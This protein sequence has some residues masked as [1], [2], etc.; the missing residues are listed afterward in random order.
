MLEG[1]KI[2]VGVTGS[3]AAY[4]AAYLTRELS[5]HGATVR[6]TMT[7]AA[8]RFVAPLTFASLSKHPVALSMYPEGE[9]S[10]SW[11]IDWA[12]WGDGMV[13]APASA[14]TI[15]KLANGISDSALTV[16]ATALR[17]D[18]FVAPAMDV[19]MYHYPALKKNLATLRSFGVKII[20][21]GTGELASGLS[22]EGRL[23][24]PEEIVEVLRAHYARRTSLRG[25]KVLITAGPTREAID[26][27]RYISNHSSGKMG[28]AL[29]EE[30]RDRGAEVT[31]VTGPTSLEI[32]AGV[33]TVKVTT[34]E[35]MASA[36]DVYR[37]ETE[38]MIAAA[39]VADFTPANVA[40]MKMKRREMSEDEMSIPL[41][42]TR[43]ILKSVGATKRANQIVVG[44]ALE[45]RNLVESARQKLIEKG[46]D[47]VVANPAGEEGV[48]FGG[49]ENRITLVEADGEMELPVM[50]KRE[51]AVAIL[52]VVDRVR[53]EKKFI[54]EK[55]SDLDN[56]GDEIGMKN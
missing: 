35:E 10:G 3:I 17:G 21:P 12:L 31:L 29:A 44:F 15:A 54:E 13:I 2:I 27:V 46:C 16:I 53:Q 45:T 6:V 18:L 23:A 42:P 24:E 11:H 50:T 1:K 56:G 26:P 38:V 33:R 28:Y 39:A 4:K 51:C 14:S 9:A 7:D 32:P 30:A 55:K 22:G 25:T 20:P 5:R 41:V 37:E 43:D 34:A 8:T 40:S 47:L 52:D 19:D 36:I 48:G 49:E